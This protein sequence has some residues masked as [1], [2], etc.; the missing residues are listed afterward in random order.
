MA[1]IKPTFTLTANS[2][3]STA[4]AGPLSIA[5]SL[6]TTDSLAVDR[7]N[8]EIIT[9]STDHIL[10][11]DGSALAAKD[12]DANIAG[13]HGMWIY[14]KNVTGSDLDIYI[15]VVDDGGLTGE[16]NANDN[17][18]RLFT[19][20]Q[21]EFAFFPFDYTRDITVDAEGAAKLEYFTFNRAI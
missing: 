3:S 17:A 15:G 7:V 11:F 10:L 18:N 12:S 5:L 21:D 6:S 2:A 13:T 19:L 9:L 4:D 14:M 1:T 20:K 8:A 16:I